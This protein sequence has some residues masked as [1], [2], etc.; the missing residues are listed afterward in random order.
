MRELPEARNEGRF[1]NATEKHLHSLCQVPEGI[2]SLGPI[3]IIVLAPGFCFCFLLGKAVPNHVNSGWKSVWGQARGYNLR[4]RDSPTCTL[5]RLAPG[6]K[7]GSFPYR[8]LGTEWFISRP[9]FILRMPSSGV[10]A[11]RVS[12]VGLLSWVGFRIYLSS[13]LPVLRDHKSPCSHARSFADV[14]SPDLA[15]RLC[16]PLWALGLVPWHS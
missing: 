7:K 6:A 13:V 10:P 11:L 16:I 12:P 3:L 5:I 1:L 15:S 8:P 9:P 2:K 4:N 14:L